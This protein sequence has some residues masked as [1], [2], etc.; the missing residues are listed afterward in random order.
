MPHPISEI[1]A[2]YDRWSPIYETNENAT[3]DLAAEVLQG[4]LSHWQDRDALE[5]GC[6]TGLNTGR[7]AEHCRML[8]ALD[9][10]TGMLH[11]ARTKVAAAHVCFGQQDIRRPW[12]LA[13]DSVDLIVCTLV[14][15]HIEDLS[16]AFEQAAR[17]LRPGGEF[18]LCELH[19]FRQMAGRQAQFTDA[20]SGKLFLVPAY[21][22]AV[23]DYLNASIKH[24][25]ELV[26][27][28]EWHD[29]AVVSETTLPRLFSL[30]IRS[31]R[32]QR[33]FALEEMG[34]PAK[35]DQENVP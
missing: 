19:P 9:F 22:H 20:G 17:I 24:G 35:G 26:R 25:F 28:D 30:Q 4:Q 1:A 15:E 31:G 3:R 29:E 34:D 7:L 16:H 33:V 23:S 13:A 14:L 10:S 18:F 6:G 21:L 27:V 11:Q 12:G 32:R 8:L 5:I 2:A